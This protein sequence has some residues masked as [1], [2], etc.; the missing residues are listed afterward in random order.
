METRANYVL[1]GAFTLAGIGGSAIAAYVLTRSG[2]PSRAVAA[3]LSVVLVVGAGAI[4]F[5]TY[6]VGELGSKIVYNPDGNVD[7]GSD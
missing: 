4:A 3:T 2:D 7:F 6:R 1:I 5:Q